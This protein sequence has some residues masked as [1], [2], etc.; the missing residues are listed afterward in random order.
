MCLVKGLSPTW[1]Y[2][3]SHYF[4]R[5]G[6]IGMNPGHAGWGWVLTKPLLFLPLRGKLGRYGTNASPVSALEAGAQ[7]LPGLAAPV[8]HGFGLGSLPPW[9]GG[10][11]LRLLGPAWL[12]ELCKGREALPMCHLP[13]PLW[14]PSGTH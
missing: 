2:S 7:A 6:K 8:F 13:A 1:L 14:A 9:Q 10:Y 11:S 4:Q 3:K 5:K 12:G